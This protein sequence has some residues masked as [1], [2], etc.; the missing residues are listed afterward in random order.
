[1]PGGCSSSPRAGAGS[2]PPGAGTAR[3]RWC[4]TWNAS[5]HAAAGPAHG[6]PV[7]RL[8]ALRRARRPPDPGHEG[9]L[10]RSGRTHAQ[11]AR[12][13]GRGLR[14]HGGAG[15]RGPRSRGAFGHRVPAPARGPPRGDGAEC[16]RRRGR[17][18]PRVPAR[19]PGGGPQGAVAARGDEARIPAGRHP[20]AAVGSGLA[21]EAHRTGARPGRPPAGAQGIRPRRRRG[22]RGRFRRVAHLS[23]GSQ[24]AR[25]PGALPRPAVGALPAGAGRVRAV[26]RASPARTA[27]ERGRAH[28]D[29]GP[30]RGARPPGL[31]AHPRRGPGH[32]GRQSG[33]VASRA[34]Q[35]VQAAALPA[36]SSTA[37]IVRSRSI[38]RSPG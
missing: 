27:R 24:G 35:V 2:P 13:T 22:G 33:R 11:G 25:V 37:S 3:A 8:W 19:S 28:P 15:P 23:P 17:P 16:A 14:R 36:E 32:R 30:V 34:A 20:A 29:R 9:S 18:R 7:A 26:R 31:P 38:A 5:P 6:L 10:P 21:R 12:R 1:M 4:S